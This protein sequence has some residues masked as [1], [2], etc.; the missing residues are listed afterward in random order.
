MLH[1]LTGVLAFAVTMLI[2]AI[3]VSSLVEMFH[4]VLGLR[5]KGL[6]LMLENFY[7]WTIAKRLKDPQVLTREKFVE[8]LTTNRAL[9]GPEPDETPSIADIK[10]PSPLMER[11]SYAKLSDVPVELAMQRMGE[12]ADHFDFIKKDREEEKDR[13]L[14]DFAQ[15]YIA[16]GQEASHYFRQRARLTSVCA[17]MVVAFA[18]NV[19]PQVLYKFYMA[20]P[21]VSAHIAKQK[22]AVNTEFENLG[23]KS[24]A[25]LAEAK[26]D[27][28]I[29]LFKAARK[30]LETSQQR[31]TEAGIPFGWTDERPFEAEQSLWIIFGGFLIGLGAPFWAGAVSTITR[32]RSLTQDLNGILRPESARKQSLNIQTETTVNAMTPPTSEAFEAARSNPNKALKKR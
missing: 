28:D 24:E 3:L 32:T 21:E 31:L 11:I 10:R 7:D 9:A 17:A 27:E 16:F 20:N 25:L 8:L 5:E 23:K 4:R 22:D 6:V 12:I 15:R 14:K 1:W 30:E 2:F 13:I 26:S 29:A 19:Q 18:F